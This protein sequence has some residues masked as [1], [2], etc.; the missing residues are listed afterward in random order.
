MSDKKWKEE[1][2]ETEKNDPYYVSGCA[3]K[4][5]LSGLI[6]GIASAGYYAGYQ[7]AIE[8]VECN[9]PSEVQE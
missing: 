5:I 6:L 3:E 2:F 9:P 7:E 8:S 1:E 4:I